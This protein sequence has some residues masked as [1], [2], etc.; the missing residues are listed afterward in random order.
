MMCHWPTWVKCLITAA[1]RM[2]SHTNWACCLCKIV[3]IYVMK[4]DFKCKFMLSAD[5]IWLKVIQL[6][7]SIITILDFLFE[8][9]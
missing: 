1:N 6:M 2:N 8:E 4:T 9:K 3:L 7:V 5:N